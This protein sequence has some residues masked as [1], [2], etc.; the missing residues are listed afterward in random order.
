MVLGKHQIITDLL[1]SWPDKGFFT[2][3][4]QHE[5]PISTIGMSPSSGETLEGNTVGSRNM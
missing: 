3:W 1:N 5:E 2:T 4:L